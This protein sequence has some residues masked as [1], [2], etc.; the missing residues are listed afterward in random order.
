VV[1]SPR[2][3]QPTFNLSSLTLHLTFGTHKSIP[4]EPIDALVHKINDILV[5]DMELTSRTLAA[6][7]T[8]DAEGAGAMG[9]ERV[10][11]GQ[12]GRLA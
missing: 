7:N 5:P 12:D 8:L 4:L 10:L 6:A 9:D 1:Q 3:I 11:P 2:N